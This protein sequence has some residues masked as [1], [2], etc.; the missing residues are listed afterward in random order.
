MSIL[1]RFKERLFGA[2]RDD[3]RHDAAR[4]GESEAELEARTVRELIAAVHNRARER[5]GRG[6]WR[7]AIL[8]LDQ[9][10]AQFPIWGEAYFDRGTCYLSLEDA[11]TARIDLSRAITLVHDDTTRGAAYLN[12]A[13]AHSQLGDPRAAIADVEAVRRHLPNRAAFAESLP[14]ALARFQRML[15]DSPPAAPTASSAT[16]VAALLEEG[17]SLKARDALVDA[18]VAFDQAVVLAPEDPE[19]YH[20]RGTV[21][22]MLHR[23]PQALADLDRAIELAPRHVAA[24]AERGIVRAETGDFDGAMRDYDLAIQVDPA[25]ATA[26]FNKGS[27]FALQG[28]FAEA[29]P[30]LDLA[31]Q[32]DPGIPD[33]YFNR[34]RCNEELGRR[35]SS[36]DDLSTFLRLRP[37]GRMSKLVRKTIARLERAGQA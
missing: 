30:H 29:M 16:R 34:G 32:I 9:V 27:A 22:C 19:T 37:D 28:R 35:Q 24:L 20:A 17:W 2:R 14:R 5:I 3:E 4:E 11:R 31:I 1:R 15:D 13:E 8:D 10:I 6:Q 36:I 26:H 21:N 7:A 18:L 25:C 12:R 33:F 23:R